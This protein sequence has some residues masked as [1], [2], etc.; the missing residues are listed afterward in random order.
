MTVV[1]PVQTSFSTGE[2][3]PALLGRTDLRAFVD[4][5]KRLTNVLVTVG[6]GVRRRPGL[7]HVTTV[8]GPGRLCLTL[9]G[10][11]RRRL[12]VLG[13]RRVLVFDDEALVADVTAPWSLDQL[14]S[15]GWAA[16]QG[17]LL[18]CHAAVPPQYVALD[19]VG[20]WRVLPWS[21]AIR[22]GA[23]PGLQV[24]R[25]P[26]AKYAA[27]DVTLEAFAGTGGIW[28]FRSDRQ[29]FN[30]AH[31][32]T[33]LRFRAA[34]VAVT[35]VSVDGTTLFGIPQQV[36]ADPARTTLWEEQAFGP[37]TG[38]PTAAIVYR[39]RL[40]VGGVPRMPQRLWMSRIGGAFDFETGEGLDDEA[41]AI[42][43]GDDAAHAI[44]GFGNG[45]ALE[46]FTAAGEWT[47]DG[48]PLSPRSV[49]AVRQ[50]GIGS[51][52]ARYVPPVAVDGASVFIGRNDDAVVEYV[53]TD[54]D[55]AY[56]AQDLAVRARHLVGTPVDLAFDD[57]L[58]S[59][60][61][62]R[63]DGGLVSS[64]IDRHSGIVAWSAHE[65]AGRVLAA[66][67]R[68][69][70]VYLLT[71]RAGHV[72]LERFDD[73]VPLDAA[74][75]VSAEVPAT[76][77]SGL[78]HLDDHVA[79]LVA[80]GNYV[81]RAMVVAGGVTSPV[82]ARELVVGLPYAHQVEPLPVVLDGQRKASLF[83][84][85]QITFEL[86]ETHALAVDL[87][88]GV[89]DVVLPAGGFSGA[90]ALRARGW[91]GRDGAPLWRVEDDRPL[92][93]HLLS[94]TSDVKVTR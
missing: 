28:S 79:M 61:V 17:G 22:D 70:I 31:V 71:E 36:I 90:K 23:A 75:V 38:Y 30:N 86:H 82:P 2:I 32:G 76:A 18:V 53:F 80:D 37:A 72:R 25:Q 60:F 13:D 55:A 3:D 85:V 92:A 67:A 49:V 8:P 15:L 1:H 29:V 45:R 9:V 66:A 83:R 35:G 50:T 33:R 26:Y 91:R 88:E 84:P 20:I 54:V 34:E 62:V 40:V 41:I 52:T 64:T 51:V 6:G 57:R 89:R 44:R 21:Y 93:F 14:A 19:P 68:D 56:Q 73:G 24:I 4:G 47:V 43:L 87:G 63:A 94:V 48:N 39:D 58:R 16:H 81:G 69:G 5:A 78:A 27:D 7:R 77:W 59:L 12:F 11:G 65:T 46:V 10:D 74:I 42:Q